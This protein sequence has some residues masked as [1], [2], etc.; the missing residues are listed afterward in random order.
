MDQTLSLCFP[1]FS[2][3]GLRHEKRSD[4]D[5]EEE[6]DDKRKRERERDES[7]CPTL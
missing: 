6:E 1:A 5:E 2:S 3:Q 7:F 4:D